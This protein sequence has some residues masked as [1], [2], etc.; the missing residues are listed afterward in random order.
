MKGSSCE[1][2]KEFT[3][4]ASEKIK[5]PSTTVIAAA[6]ENLG[7]SLKYPFRSG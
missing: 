3:R 6:T 1:P 4:S 5:S 7:T 2:V